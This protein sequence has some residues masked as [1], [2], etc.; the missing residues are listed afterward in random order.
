MSIALYNPTTEHEE[1]GFR[2]PSTLHLNAI[3]LNFERESVRL[4]P[5]AHRN[6]VNSENVPLAVYHNS[7][8]L[9]DPP[10]NPFYPSPYDLSHLSY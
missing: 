8:R 10:F 2:R 5:P 9:L 1:P 3:Q 4:L 6:S 7:S